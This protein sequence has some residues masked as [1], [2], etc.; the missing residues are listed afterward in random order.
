[1][2]E[3]Y[4]WINNIGN[5]HDIDGFFNFW[6]FSYGYGVMRLEKIM[7]GKRHIIENSSRR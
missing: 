7:K 2:N 6:Y 5:A 3:N 4:N 1:M